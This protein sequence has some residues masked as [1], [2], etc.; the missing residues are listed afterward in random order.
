[1]RRQEKIKEKVP[2]P[3]GSGSQLTVEDV[4]GVL[5]LIA[6]AIGALTDSIRNEMAMNMVI[7][8]RRSK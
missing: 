2:R 3:S 1:V 6:I 8:P 7:S 5:L 4:K